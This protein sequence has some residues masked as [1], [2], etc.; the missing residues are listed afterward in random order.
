MLVS[1]RPKHDWN[2]ENWKDL[3]PRLLLY[4]RGRVDRYPQFTD[5]RN[6]THDLVQS[7]IC[8]TI[9]GTR[10]W[11][12]KAYPT[13]F[14]FLCSVIRSDLNHRITEVI[15]ESQMQEEVRH[16][17]TAGAHSPESMIACEDDLR[18]FLLG[19]HGKSP[20]LA[21]L[22]FLIVYEGLTGTQELANAMGISPE[23]VN[24]LK[25]RF[26]RAFSRFR[27]TA[28]RVEPKQ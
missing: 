4:A 3:V 9:D 24:N 28:F 18:K 19:L 13:L 20:T 1:N 21:E 23:Q 6:L 25:K 14:L 26:R 27:E 15:Q 16:N 8:K 2:T 7:A 12:K 10:R 17:V 5:R 22:A 11:N